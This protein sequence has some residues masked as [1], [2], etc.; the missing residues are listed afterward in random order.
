MKNTQRGFIV[1]LLIAIIAVLV[2]GGG[3]YLYT[4]NNSQ[5]P[6]ALQAT[7]S[8]LATSSNQYAGWKTY[9]N[10]KYGFSFK[11]PAGYDLKTETAI[12]SNQELMLGINKNQEYTYVTLSKVPNTEWTANGT[13]ICDTKPATAGCNYYKLNEKFDVGGIVAR[14]ISL[15]G[16]GGETERVM[17]VR[18]GI[19][20]DISQF[21]I[22]SKI[23]VRD[24]ANTFKFT[25]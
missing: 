18:D 21:K 23:L 22:D 13:Y 6:T 12:P 16:S 8:L 3:V 24:I 11:Y 4:Q 7:N 5:Q 25:K 15:G 10:T 14:D 9:S 1:P 19:L 20:F 2:V 17:F